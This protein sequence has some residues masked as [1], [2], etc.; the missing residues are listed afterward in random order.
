MRTR[1]PLRADN[2]D[3]I[4]RVVIHDERCKYWL[5]AVIL[6]SYGNSISLTSRVIQLK[7]LFEHSFLRFFI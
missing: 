3:A 4:Y 5:S 1:A 6:Y 2:A 7:S